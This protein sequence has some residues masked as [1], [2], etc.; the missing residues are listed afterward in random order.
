MAMRNA[1]IIATVRHKFQTL[2]AIMDQSIRRLWAACGAAALGWGALTAL[3]NRCARMISTTSTLAT[4]FRMVS[5][6]SKLMNLFL[7]ES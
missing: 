4:S 2:C 6:D 3:R 7:H 5:T 1:T